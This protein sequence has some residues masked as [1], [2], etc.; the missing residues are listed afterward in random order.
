M[1][2][3]IRRS[4]LTCLEVLPQIPKV[5]FDLRIYTTLW[6]RGKVST[7]RNLQAGLFTIGLLVHAHLV[8]SEH[9]CSL[10]RIVGVSNYPNGGIKQYQRSQSSSDRLWHICKSIS[11]V[12]DF[13]G[14]E[15]R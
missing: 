5:H 3:Y 1:P 8:L 6:H 13:S 7:K 2:I 10:I 15:E 11:D 14:V 4:F 12:C 9:L